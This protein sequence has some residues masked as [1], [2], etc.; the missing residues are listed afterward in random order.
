MDS[1]NHVTID[2]D[3]AFSALPTVHGEARCS[4]S[5]SLDDCIAMC[6]I[7]LIK[8]LCNCSATT[9]SMLS[10]PS[11]KDCDL[12]L[13]KSCLKFNGISDSYCASSCLGLCNRMAFTF[14]NSPK[15]AVYRSCG[16]SITLTNMNYPVFEESFQWGIND[17]IGAVG[18]T[19]FLFLGL[20]FHSILNSIYNILL[21]VFAKCKQ[22][23]KDRNIARD[24][25]AVIE[26]NLP[27]QI[28]SA[29]N[30]I[31]TG[32]MSHKNFLK[33]TWRKMYHWLP[34]NNFNGITLLLFSCLTL[35]MGS[36]FIHKYRTDPTVPNMNLMLGQ[37]ISLPKSTICLDL[38]FGEL[39]SLT[40][41]NHAS[42]T[43]YQKNLETYFQNTSLSKEKIL[44]PDKWPN[45]L[46]NVV[47]AYLEFMTDNEANTAFNMTDRPDGT[48]I[49][50][51]LPSR[52]NSDDLYLAIL[53]LEEKMQKFNLTSNE[54][55]QKFGGEVNKFYFSLQAIQTNIRA[56]SSMMEQEIPINFTTS[57]SYYGICYQVSFDRH[58]FYDGQNQM[59]K[60]TTAD[61][62]K[63]LPNSQ[64]INQNR[65]FAVDFTDGNKTGLELTLHID[66]GVSTVAEFPTLNSIRVDSVYRSLPIVVNGGS[67]RCSDTIS[68]EGCIAKCRVHLIQKL[69][70]C[71]ATSWYYL[72]PTNLRECRASDYFS[73]LEYGSTNNSNC[74]SKCVNLCERWKFL[75]DELTINEKNKID[76]GLIELQ[77]IKFDYPIFAEEVA[78]TFD[79]ISGS[80]GNVI[81]CYLG[82]DF[83]TI[84]LF[85]VEKAKWFFTFIF[86]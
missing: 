2:V 37:K 21:I 70:N 31:R 4:V 75:S 12:Q 80:F 42:K 57:V 78:W 29:E 81:Q 23:R 79:T 66:E 36:D 11:I 43:Y 22:A 77:I 24:Q 72:I 27:N 30:A 46:L 62:W 83:S 17:L 9:W 47:H 40:E 6:R 41:N 14:S 67:A 73:C 86:R 71:S 65:T 39:D 54:L 49:S 74:M 55:R 48:G 10:A 60:I 35:Q 13:Y 34:F 38:D 53:L 63:T 50:S 26:I 20:D 25:D 64:S 61:I 8:N 16:F 58:P 85:A 33:M 3:A 19:I 28:S 45:V 7:N 52:R 32:N 15:A 76:G 51:L 84:I 82:L 1:I 44:D 68:Q 5:L 69:C 59:I 18:G 56:N